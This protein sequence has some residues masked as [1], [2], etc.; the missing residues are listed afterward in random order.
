MVLGFIGLLLFL[1]TAFAQESHEH[2]QPP[3]AELVSADVPFEASFENV[4]PADCCKKTI[5]T[6]LKLH[7]KDSN[8][9]VRPKDLDVVHTERI[10]LLITDTSLT[11]YQHI[12]P[13][14]TKAPGIYSFSWTPSV[15]NSYKMW[16]NLT[17]KG[18]KTDIYIPIALTNFEGGP[19]LEKQETTTYRYAPFS[20]DLSFEEPLQAGKAVMGKVIIN[21]ERGLP[22][23]DLQPVMGA[24]AHIVAFHEDMDEVAHVHPMGPEPTKMTDRG[25]PTLDFHLEPKKPGFYK[26]WVQIH[27]RNKDHYIPFGIRVSS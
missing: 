18:Q 1:S 11:D 6:N 15:S 10:H 2:H 12:H 26:L 9:P 25:G 14:P 7:F 8:K 19:K 20:V 22:I 23:K 21:D 24:F 4:G 16:V 17:P 13:N 5:R 27:Y 3:S